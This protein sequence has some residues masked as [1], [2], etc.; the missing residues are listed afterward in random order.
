MT[1]R[2]KFFSV[3]RHQNTKKKKKIQ[4]YHDTEIQKTYRA[5]NDGAFSATRTIKVVGWGKGAGSK[6]QELV[7]RMEPGL[8]MTKVSVVVCPPTLLL[9][10]VNWSLHLVLL[11]GFLGSIA[12]ESSH[13]HLVAPPVGIWNIFFGTRKYE[14]RA[15]EQKASKDERKVSLSFVSLC[16]VLFVPAFPACFSGDWCTERNET[17]EMFPLITKKLKKTYEEN[18]WH[19]KQLDSI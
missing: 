13:R 1:S 3:Q 12:T 10:C 11:R 6:G 8:R 4:K 19:C 5:Q 16:S 9:H 2:R 15:K 18:I 14:L 7:Q 17:M